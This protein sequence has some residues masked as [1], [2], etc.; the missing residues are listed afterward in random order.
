MD[1]SAAPFELQPGFYRVGFVGSMTL[2]PRSGGT[3][4]FQLQLLTDTGFPIT[5]MAK[6]LGA[7]GVSERT[8]QYIWMPVAGQIQ[9]VVRVATNCGGASVQGVLAVERVGDPY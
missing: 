5:D 3:S 4:E 7:D 9:P 8:F 2:A 6:S 1:T